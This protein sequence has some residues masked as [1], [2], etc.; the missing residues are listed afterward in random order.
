MNCL[1]IVNRHCCTVLYTPLS[2]ILPFTDVSSASLDLIRDCTFLLSS[3]WLHA[4]GRPTSLLSPTIKCR[5]ELWSS[6]SNSAYETSQWP[7]YVWCASG[8]L[9]ILVEWPRTFDSLLLNYEP[10]LAPLGTLPI[11]SWRSCLLHACVRALQRR[12]LVCCMVWSQLWCAANAGLAGSAC[13]PQTNL[14]WNISR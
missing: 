3:I 13:C 11:T 5:Q 10:W 8:Y 1:S 2:V 7:H 12:C 4:N 14:V 9:A 6:F